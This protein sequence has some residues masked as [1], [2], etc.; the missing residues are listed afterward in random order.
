M[1]RGSAQQA[2][3]S[4]A[5]SWRISSYGTWCS[6][7]SFIALLAG[8]EEGLDMV[9]AFF[10]QFVAWHGNHGGLDGPA[11]LGRWTN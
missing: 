8:S 1:F 6:A 4:M 11:M 7:F 9:D 5:M 3:A 10:V 2:W